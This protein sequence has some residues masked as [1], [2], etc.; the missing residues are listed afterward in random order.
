MPSTNGHSPESNVGK[1]AL[2]LRVSSD[3][4][5]ER[6]SIR[7]QREFFEQYCTLYGLEVTETY[8]DD[9][10]SGT[11]PLHERPEGRRLLEDARADRFETLLVYRLDRLGRSLLIIVD[12]HDRLQ[13][14]GVSL[15][16]ATEPID[17]SN[18]SG[19]LIFQMLASFA[20]YERETIRERT[21]AGLH[22]AFRSGRHFGVAPYGYRADEHGYLLV[23]PE[24][25]EIVRGIIERVAEGS[26][27]YAETKRL[28]DLGIPTPG[29]RYGSKKRPGSRLWSVATVSNIVH[30]SAYSGIHK[31]KTN[32]GKDVIEQAVTPVL[33][34]Q[35]IQERA[36]TALKENKRYP[37]RNNNRRYLLRGLVK[38]ATC[39][40]ACTG[41]SAIRRDKKYHYYTCHVGR[42]KNFGTG[43]SHKPPYVKASWLEELV[44]TDVRRFLE[45]PQEILERV[46]EQL[47][48]EDNA[49][50]LEARR[51][52]LAKRLAVRQTEKDRYIRTYAQG[53][54]SEEE[55]D[56]YLTDLKNQTY[57]LRLLLESVEA[58]LSNR[59][60]RTALTDTT[61]AWLLSLR[62]RLAE[63]EEDTEEAFRERRQ[64][65][66]L[67]VAST[68][69]RQAAR[70]WAHRDPRN[71]P[72]RSADVVG[73]TGGRFVYGIFQ[74]R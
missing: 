51:D 48:S 11:A 64:L 33:D 35:D 44:W 23:V 55:L 57:N 42:T 20:E 26:S 62:Q 9:G 41:Q 19:R 32:G 29:W 74:E 6:E 45:D 40:S 38:C 60:E 58:D 71:L 61:H 25:A 4:Q 46:R 72:L 3:E 24:E 17:T 68:L 67:L 28:N 10:V 43:R 59:R 15:R 47:G 8:A 50:E 13:A 34:N 53:Y 73:S 49:A 39:G 63:V 56:V 16:S 7:T 31:V 69:G 12:A 14:A 30:Q 66:K 21:R 1:V 22:R 5:R 65:V 52:E 27:L 54:I 18:P 37:N 36:Q 2:Y 70:G